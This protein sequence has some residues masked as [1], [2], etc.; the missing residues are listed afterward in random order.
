MAMLIETWG[1]RMD[2]LGVPMDGGEVEGW[3]Q[4]R[5]ARVQVKHL[6]SRVARK[7][8]VPI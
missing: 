4:G 6:V 2:R 7:G 5:W 8:W 3:V 1:V